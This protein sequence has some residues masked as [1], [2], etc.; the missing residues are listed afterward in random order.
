VSLRMSV[1]SQRSL[2]VVH[3][4]V[5]DEPEEATLTSTRALLGPGRTFSTTDVA[6]ALARGDPHGSSAGGNADGVGRIRAA[7]GTENGDSLSPPSVVGATEAW[8]G[9]RS[10][11]NPLL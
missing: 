4:I 5:S 8:S 10:D 2:N 6:A 7:N 11:R 9:A 3:R 1:P